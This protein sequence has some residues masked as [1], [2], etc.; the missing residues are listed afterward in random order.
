MTRRTQSIERATI[1]SRKIKSERTMKQK[2]AWTAIRNQLHKLDVPTLVN[3]VKDLH[4]A[5]PTN[6]DFLAARFLADEAPTGADRPIETFRRRIREIFNTR[7]HKVRLADGRKAIRE[8]RKATGDLLGTVDLMLSYVEEGT[9]FTCQYGDIDEPFYNS[10]CSVLAELRELLL[11]PTAECYP[12]MEPRLALVKQQAA[13][14]GWGFG[15]FVHD[16]ADELA[17]RFSSSA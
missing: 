4:D 5:T 14:I 12:V 13:G 9:E 17:E 11:G 3:L 6:R 15:D 1:P 16:V 10:L 8:Y 2:S 7:D